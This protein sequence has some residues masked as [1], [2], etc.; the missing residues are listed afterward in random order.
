MKPILLVPMAGKGQR[1]IDQGYKT[2]KQFIDVAGKTMIEWSFRSFNWKECQVIFIVR[3]DHIDNW[4]VDVKLKKIFGEDIII[5]I[6]EHDT[7]GTV[8]S[9][10]LAKKYIDKDIPL[11]ITTLDVYFR[12]HFDMNEIKDLKVDGCLL[13]IETDNPAYSYCKLDE[14]GFVEK[15]AEKE[16]I[17]THGNVG[18]YCFSKGSNFV[19]YAEQLVKE[20]IRS[21]NEFYIAPLYN[22]LIEDGLKINTKAIEEQFHMGTPDELNHFLE[23]QA[24][25]IKNEIW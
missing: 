11:G 9:C 10:L 18:F 13:T 1:F 17:S 15:T 20:N 14:E 12:P 24:D 22:L 21:K 7:D 16:V 25:I 8:S 2:P 23:N 3:R 19:Q 4:A 6:A 5:I